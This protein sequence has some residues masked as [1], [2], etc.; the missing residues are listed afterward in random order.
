MDKQKQQ[1][2]KESYDPPN[3]TEQCKVGELL[4]SSA[5]IPASELWKI[6]KEML[7]D[8]NIKSYLTYIQK[9]KMS[10]SYIE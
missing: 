7:M 8:E 2:S 6:M 5:F 3:L 1:L 9:R 4:L 10:G